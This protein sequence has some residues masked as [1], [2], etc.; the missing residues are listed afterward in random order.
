MNCYVSI[1][2][3]VYVLPTCLLTAQLRQKGRVP[4]FE[5]LSAN[6]VSLTVRLQILQCK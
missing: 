3:A 1:F 2:T 5:T 6:V 4:S